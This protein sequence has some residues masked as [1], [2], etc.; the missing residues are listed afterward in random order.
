MGRR[1]RIKNTAV[2]SKGIGKVIPGLALFQNLN[3]KL[4]R[5]DFIVAITVFAVLV[6]SAMAYGDLAGVTPVAG[7][8]VAIGAMIMYAQFG[9]SKQVIMGPEATT[10]IMTAT[11][12]APRL[13]ATRC[14]MLHWQQ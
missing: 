12:V 2:K 10:A 13:P 6:P 9:T 7:L 5:T 8:Y 1:F 3:L 11:T 14:V 4:L